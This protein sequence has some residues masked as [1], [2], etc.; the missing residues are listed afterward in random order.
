MGTMGTTVCECGCL[1][2]LPTRKGAA[3]SNSRQ[4]AGARHCQMERS[5]TPHIT[6]SSPP[7]PPKIV[8]ASQCAQA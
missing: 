3:Q 7:S 1:S 4:C 8:Q 6:M 2:L 5:G